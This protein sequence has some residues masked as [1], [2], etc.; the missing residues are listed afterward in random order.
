MG[1][2]QRL[3]VGSPVA[4]EIK[5]PLYKSQM[6]QEAFSVEFALCWLLRVVWFPPQSKKHSV[7]ELGVND[8]A[9][10]CVFLDQVS[11]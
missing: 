10:V 8:R 5:D 3:S 9:N 11:L 1:A 6:S 7:D 4:S 2:A